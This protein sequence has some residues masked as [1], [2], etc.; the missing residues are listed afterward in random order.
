[1]TTVQDL[2]GRIGHWQVGVPPSGPMDAG[3]TAWATSPWATPR[4]RRGWSSP[5]PGPSCGS[6]YPTVVCVTGAPADVTVDGEPAPSGSRSTWQPARCSRSAPRS[7]PDCGL[8]I[9]VRGGLDVPTYLGS[10]STFTLGGFGGHGGRAL[11]PGDVL[12]P[13]SQ[14]A[15][16][17]H[18]A[19]AEGETLTRIGGPTPPERRPHLTSTWQL[20]VT[21]GPHAAPEFFTR[22]DIDTLYATDYEVH[23]NSART[24]VRLIGPRPTWA[25]SDGGEAGLHPS[26]IHDTPYSVGALDFTGDTPILL[27]PDG[28]SPR[29]FRLPGG[30]R[31]R[32]AVEAGPAASGDTVRFVPVREADAAALDA[33]RGAATVPTRGGDGDDGVLGRMDPSGDTAGRPA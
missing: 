12:R 23:F 22:D 24:G 5:R 33:H 29:R 8:A 28:P 4:E 14:D 11:A 3:V 1:M 6:R 17:P 30:R 32:R 16:A 31:E 21:E 25:R 2:P 7:A 27:G 18:P 15:E 19:F 9:A 26:N 10:A 13:G 20:G